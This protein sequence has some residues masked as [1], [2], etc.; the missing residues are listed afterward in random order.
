MTRTGNL[1]SRSCPCF[2]VPISPGLSG[3]SRLITVP[4]RIF[5][6]PVSL[7]NFSIS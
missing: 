5:H 6:R 4:S 3:T 2:S 7:M 1:F